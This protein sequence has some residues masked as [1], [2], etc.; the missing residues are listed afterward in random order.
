MRGGTWKNDTTSGSSSCTSGA[1]LLSGGRG[2]YENWGLRAAMDV[3]G[4]EDETT[5]TCPD[6]EITV[7]LNDSVSIEFVYIPPGKFVMGGHNTEEGRFNCVEVPHHPVQIT[8]GFYLGKYPVTQEQYMALMNGKNPSKSTKHPKCPV[9]NIGVDDANGFC[10]AAS[11]VT[12]SNI[13]LPTEAEWEYASRGTTNGTSADPQ[14]FFG[15]DGSKLVE[16]AWCKQ[17]ADGKSHPVGLKK[18]NPFGI[19]DIYGNV[20]ERVSDNYHK[21]YYGQGKGEIMVDPTGPSEGTQSK[22]KYELPSIPESGKYS[23]TAKV[24]TVTANQRLRV[25]TSKHEDEK[26]Q[27]LKLLYT[28]GEWK[29]TEPIMLEL[30]EGPNILYFWRD[31]PPQYGVSIK[32]FVLTKET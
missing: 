6:T 14:C 31:A 9:D 17:N 27:V 16:Y 30:K 23:L 5:S 10:T 24:C 3:D 18:P 1:R 28:L 11:E 21:D 26:G 20:C 19:Y 2:K 22:L 32:E 7:D 13:R 25:S 15:S 12:G 8:K 4:G 29:E